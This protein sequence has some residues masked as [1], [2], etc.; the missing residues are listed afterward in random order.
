MY[1]KVFLGLEEA[2]KAVDAILATA[3][4]KEPFYPIAVA[5]VDLCGDL[6]YFAKLDGTF[7]NQV[8]MA[9]NKAY[10]AALLRRSTAV[11]GENTRKWNLSLGSW[12]DSRYTDVA[13]GVC[14]T[15][16]DGKPLAGIGVSGIPTP[17]GDEELVLFGPK[18]LGLMIK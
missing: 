5:V 10:T 16:K 3:T 6:I 11:F 17:E 14:I 9:I 7:P 4:K 13:G 18:A 15:T 12:V 2:Q 8:R 1:Q